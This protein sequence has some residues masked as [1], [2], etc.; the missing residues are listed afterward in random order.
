MKWLFAQLKGV[1]LLTLF[2]LTPHRSD[3]VS[4][5]RAG[6]LLAEANHMAGA[7]SRE[8]SAVMWPEEEATGRSSGACFQRLM[9]SVTRRSRG[10]S[11]GQSSPDRPSGSFG[12]QKAIDRVYEPSEEKIAAKLCPF[13]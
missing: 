4:G 13:C 6:V 3:P 5:V 10:T 2:G 8:Q 9:R 12:T 1:F 7:S 11:P